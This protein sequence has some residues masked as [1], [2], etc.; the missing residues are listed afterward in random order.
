MDVVRRIFILFVI[1]FLISFASATDYYVSQN[2]AGSRN[3]FSL[4]N[5][6][7][8]ADISDDTYRG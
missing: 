3:G 2:G 6:W 7:S 5:A 1:V 8:V 4:D